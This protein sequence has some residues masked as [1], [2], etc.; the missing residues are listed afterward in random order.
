MLYLINCGAGSDEQKSMVFFG[1]CRH[2]NLDAV[3]GLV[4]VHNVD[5][6]GEL[7]LAIDSVNC[8]MCTVTIME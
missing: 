7:V 2:G 4:E 1:A 5:L 8:H 6:N 3:K